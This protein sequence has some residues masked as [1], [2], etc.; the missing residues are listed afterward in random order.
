M[1]AIDH[2]VF[3]TGTDTGVGKTRVAVQLLRQWAAQGLPVAGL[4][5]VAAG[6]AVTPDGLRNEDALALAAAGSVPLAY[7]DINPVCLAWATAPHLAAAAVGR[8]L[9]AASLV[10]HCRQVA[11]RAARV[12]V[13]GAGGWL[14]PLDDPDL[15]GSTGPTLADLAAGLGLPV[16]LVVGVRLGCLNHALLTAAAVRASGLPL[17]GWVGS[18]VD[19]AFAEADDYRRALARR[20]PAPCAGWLPWDPSG[21]SLLASPHA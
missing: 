16:L 4:K 10:A 15:D 21:R 7:D 18:V 9:A 19:P 17:A 14:V 12:V 5:P 2:S 8:Q 11:A 6:A 13:E 3:V 1:I 20:L